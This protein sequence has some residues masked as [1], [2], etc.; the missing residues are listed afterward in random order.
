VGTVLYELL[1]KPLAVTLASS[2]IEV[3]TVRNNMSL[4]Q[5]FN[6]TNPDPVLTDQLLSNYNTARRQGT[7]ATGLLVISIAANQSVTIPE[8]ARF[9]CGGVLLKPVKTFVGSVGTI[10]TEDTGNIAYVQA[11]DFDSTTKV[12]TITAETVE[13]TATVLSSG[14]SCTVLNLSDSAIKGVQ[15]GSTFVGGSVEETTN[16]LL[17]RARTSIS[18]KVLTGRDN[19]RA[20]LQDSAP[21]TVLDTASFGMGDALQLRDSIN[22]GGISTGA[23]VDTYVQ[24]ASVPTTTTI[25]VQGSRDTSGTWTV[26][27]TD[28]AYAG[29]Y[30]VIA[31]RDGNKVITEFTNEVGFQ[32]GQPTPLMTKVVHGRYSKYQT[33]Q[34]TFIDEDIDAATTTHDFDLDVFFMPGIAAIQDF[35]NSVEVRSFSFDN[36]IKAVVPVVI[37]ASVEV[38]YI[39]GLTPPSAEKIAQQIS[40]IINLKAIGTDSLQSSDIVYAVKLL[41]PQGTVRMPLQ[42]DGR[43]FLPDGTQAFSNSTS[44]IKIA[45]AEGISK[46]NT[47]FFSFPSDIFVTLTEV[48][49]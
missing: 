42:L 5:V 48:K 25:T 28:S 44:H 8:T 41:F 26:P 35:V 31:V 47:K 37:S 11:R 19:I 9:D 43:V 23:H 1:I 49:L 38:E 39:Q 20:F 18:A 22:N 45:E 17:A 6:S 33:L 7:V 30:A 3:D 29:A 15:V 27:V 32:V 40:D 21:V 12:F 24:T 10:T 16:E 13:P 14:Q 46:E 34:V 36:V 2:S 4:L